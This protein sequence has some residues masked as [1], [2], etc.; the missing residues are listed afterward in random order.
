MTNKKIYTPTSPPHPFYPAATSSLHHAISPPPS[1]GRESKAIP[2]V[3]P[4]S[5][6]KAT[7]ISTTSTHS[8][9]KENLLSNNESITRKVAGPS[10]STTS[11]S[12]AAAAVAVAVSGNST[13]K[14][15]EALLL[16]FDGKTLHQ[17]KQLLG[18]KLFPLVKVSNSY[19]VLGAIEL[20]LL[21]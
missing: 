4:P 1:T 21:L 18:D 13:E 12:A 7:S 10:S 19:H 8:L 11:S 15:I 20:T 3:A 2:I 14:E 9:T 5:P 17:Q 6:C 16:S